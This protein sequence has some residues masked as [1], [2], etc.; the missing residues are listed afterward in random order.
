[1]EILEGARSRAK[2][3]R[4]KVREMSNKDKELRKEAGRGRERRYREKKALE[5]G[6]CNG[7]LAL[8]VSP[9]HTTTGRS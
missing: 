4:D 5:S 7:V 9:R 2:K 6:K 1:M 3:S 8:D